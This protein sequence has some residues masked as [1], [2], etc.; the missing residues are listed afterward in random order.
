[1]SE[2]PLTIRPTATDLA[3]PLDEPFDQL[4]DATLRQVAAS[5]ARI[6][7]QTFKLWREWC[8]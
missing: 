3:Q 5:S 8:L 7:G 2:N 4:T 6:Y 1:M